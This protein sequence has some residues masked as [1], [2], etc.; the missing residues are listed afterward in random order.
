MLH[1]LCEDC[2]DESLLLHV[3]QNVTEDVTFS[4]MLTDLFQD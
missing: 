2:G 3:E 4:Y 1:H